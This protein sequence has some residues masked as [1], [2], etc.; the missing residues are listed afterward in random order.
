VSN[1]RRL[2][3]RPRPPDEIEGAFRDALREGCPHCGSTRVT[4]RF[5]GVVWRYTLLCGADCPTHADQ[6]LAHR[7]AVDA[8]ERAGAAAGVPLSYRPCDSAVVEG[9]V[10]AQPAR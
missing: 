3:P 5:T 10:V 4:G 6:R 7:V 8:A 1:A 9:A 2:K